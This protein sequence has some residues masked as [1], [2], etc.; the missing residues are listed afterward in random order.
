MRILHILATSKCSGAENVVCQIIKLFDG[1]IEMAYCSPRGEIEKK[2]EKENIK[3][4]PIS[5]LSRKE[6]RKAI[7]VYKPDIIHA[8]DFRASIVVA[9]SNFNGKII[10]QIHQTPTFL[11]TRNIRS[12]IYLLSTKRYYK[13]VGVS[14]KI[15]ENYIFNDK[16]KNKYI[17]IHNCINKDEIL[18]KSKLYNCDENYD[19]LFFGRLESVKNPIRFINIVETIVKQNSNIKA[20]IIGDGT[21]TNIC[22]ET[23]KNKNLQN[24]IK[25]LGFISNP[26]PIIKK[27][28]L[29][30]IT[31]DW[32]GIPMSAIESMSLSAVVLSNGVGG[33]E[34]MFK[35]IQFLIC[36]NNQEY[37]N[38]ILLLL[39][40]NIEYRKYQNLCIKLTDKFSNTN[41]WIN[42]FNNIY[43]QG[44]RNE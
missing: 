9:M 42:E 36:E 11:K 27:C 26:F 17:T 18:Y 16:I 34:E 35:D 15:F 13:I 37:I 25:M 12:L 10:S 43:V 29:M 1:K 23:I 5:K 21:L 32:E 33:L 8:H 40:D 4:I 14:N 2:L 41:K 39:S 7:K 30:I 31:S 20:V 44:E 3:Y 6:I 38:K 28:K 22:E 19:L 24:N